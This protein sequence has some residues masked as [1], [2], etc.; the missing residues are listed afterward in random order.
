MTAQVRR[1]TDAAWV[2]NFLYGFP[3]ELKIFYMQKMPR[4]EGEQGSV[5]TESCELLMPGVGEIADMWNSDLPIAVMEELL[6]AYKR[7]GID[8]APY[9]W[10]TDQR[11]YGI[12]LH[13]G[14]VLG[15]EFLAWLA[16]RF[17]VRECTLYY[18][19]WPGRATP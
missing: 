9:Y 3:T 6:V 15:V 14:Y 8:P 5:Y 13:G 10:F 18:P 7:K 1:S 16:N 2:P 4:K 12:C 17:T 11:K 19:R